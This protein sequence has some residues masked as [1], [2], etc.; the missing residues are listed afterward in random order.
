[1]NTT[2]PIS[3][4]T[5]VRKYPSKVNKAIMSYK[6]KGIFAKISICKYSVLYT[7]EIYNNLIKKEKCYFK[8]KSQ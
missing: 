5:T 4:W 2:I 7:L 3:V 1:M 8:R 6:K